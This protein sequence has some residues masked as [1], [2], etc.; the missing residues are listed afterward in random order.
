MPVNVP[1]LGEAKVYSV[2]F[3]K[4]ETPR[5]VYFIVFALMLG[6]GCLVYYFQNKK[7]RSKLQKI[8]KH[9]D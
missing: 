1:G 4:K 6:L 8:K 9:V 7:H 5:I 2:N 3:N